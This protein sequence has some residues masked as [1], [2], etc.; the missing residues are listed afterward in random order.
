MATAD[1][2][3][4]VSALPGSGVRDPGSVVRDPGP[5]EAV[6]SAPTVQS[7]ITGGTGE[8]TGSFTEKQA[9]DLA[10]VLN[11]G[12]LPVELQRQ[13]VRTVSPLLGQESLR[14]GLV[15]RTDTIADS[16]R[17]GQ[18]SGRENPGRPES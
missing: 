11:S 10:V 18:P 6:E 12:A 4:A 17:P 1:T 15:S 9:K 13:E 8:I 2:H 3:F 14:Q 7:P 16:A 5:E